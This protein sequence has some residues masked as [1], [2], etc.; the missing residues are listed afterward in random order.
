MS[1]AGSQDQWSSWSFSKCSSSEYGAPE[2]RCQIL[3][4]PGGVGEVKVEILPER[5]RTHLVPFRI[6]PSTSTGRTLSI[7]GPLALPR[8]YKSIEVIPIRG[9]PL[10]Y[11]ADDGPGFEFG[12][13]VAVLA[14]LRKVPDEIR[15]RPA[16]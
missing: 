13:I 1:C 5:P 12:M 14:D 15:A 6:K 11:G 7:L 10:I 16:V 2:G 8:R 9:R 3:P 4:R